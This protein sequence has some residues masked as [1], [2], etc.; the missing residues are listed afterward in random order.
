MPEP[1]RANAELAIEELADALSVADQCRRTLRS[2]TICLSLTPETPSE[3]MAAKAM[4]DS[5]RVGVHR[6]RILPP[7]CLPSVSDA[8]FDRLEGMSL[9][10]NSLSEIS[11][12]GR[13]R[14]LFRL[15]E[16]VFGSALSSLKKP[17]YE[18]LHDAP[19]PMEFTKKETDGAHRISPVLLIEFPRVAGSG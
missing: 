2:P 3:L 14:D 19:H 8:S 9:L 6:P 1:A 12:I 10:A 11:P 5:T 15:F 18:F 16:A 13:S 4:A 17:L 7:L